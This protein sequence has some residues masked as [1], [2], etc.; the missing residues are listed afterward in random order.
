LEDLTD[1]HEAAYYFA[2]LP[3]TYDRRNPYIFSSME[4]NAPK[5]VDLLHAYNGVMPKF[6]ETFYIEG[7]ESHSL[8]LTR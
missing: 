2:N 8:S 6:V 4:T 3:T 7:S 1:D 5:I